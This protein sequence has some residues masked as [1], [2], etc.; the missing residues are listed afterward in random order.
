MPALELNGK[1]KDEPPVPILGIVAEV[2]LMPPCIRVTTVEPAGLAATVP[3]TSQSPAVNEIDVTL[4][5][6]PD[7]RATAE[8][9]A[10]D[11]LT[12]SPTLPAFALLFVVVPTMPFV[13]DGVKLPVADSVVKAPAAA[14]VPPIAGGE[15]R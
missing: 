4:A 12:N 1:L 15:A 14:A 3:H 5:G 9:A 13:C 11:E 10:T 6:V 2:V 7:V 8:P